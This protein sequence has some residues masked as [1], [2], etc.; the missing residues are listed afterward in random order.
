MLGELGRG[1]FAIVYS[2][3]DYKRN[4]YLAV[5]V[6]RP[7]FVAAPDIPRRFQREVQF[8][9]ELDHPNILPVSFAD[10]AE[11]LIYF[12]MPRVKG[13]TLR[14]RL[15][16]ERPLAIPFARRIVTGLADGLG[17]AHAHGLIHRDVK[18]ANIMID[19]RE[20]P[21]LLDFGIAKSLAVK[22][23]SLTLTG[24]AI[25]T[26]TYMSPEQAASSSTVRMQSDVYSLGVVAFEM[27]TGEVPFPGD[28]IVSMA[29]KQT[30]ERPPDPRALRPEIP[31]D[32]ADAVM[33]CLERDPLARWPS[34][35]EL[36]AALA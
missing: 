28:A 16:R 7:E 9:S 8:I 13:E 21:L 33:R 19:E 32:L 4:R 11:G 23:A 1:G 6:L 18:P 15:E 22:G 26:P 24:T 3:R 10:E 17:Y 14:R 29:E 12:A 25:G 35:K 31:D 2:V 30:V 27:L 5:K 34:G 20:R 36:A